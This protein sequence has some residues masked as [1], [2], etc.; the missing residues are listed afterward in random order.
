MFK[1]ALD[2]TAEASVNNFDRIEIWRHPPLTPQTYAVG[3]G[4]V[5]LFEPALLESFAGSG[6]VDSMKRT[7]D[8]LVIGLGLI[9]MIR[10]TPERIW[11]RKPGS[12]YTG[13]D[14]CFEFRMLTPLKQAQRQAPTGHATDPLKRWKAPA[15]KGPPLLE[16]K[17]LVID[18]SYDHG[19][20]VQRNQHFHPVQRLIKN[21]HLYESPNGVPKDL[22]DAYVVRLAFRSETN[23]DVT[24]SCRNNWRRAVKYACSQEGQPGV[25]DPEVQRLGGIK[26]TVGGKAVNE[27]LGKRGRGRGS[28]RGR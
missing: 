16:D 12:Q 23:A 26:R 21:V 14:F 9:K 17:D 1:G 11:K 3:Q 7:T 10:R 27:G 15:I 25:A 5:I 24:S 19:L 2:A 18:W 22:G 13:R 8:K 20:D 6:G 4:A 28:G